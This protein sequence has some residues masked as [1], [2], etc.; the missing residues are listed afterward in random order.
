MIQ[1]ARG[2]AARERSMDA[3]RKLEPVEPPGLETGVVERTTGGLA[4]R[5]QTG[6]C[7]A[8]R[9]KSCLVVPE[10][11]DR[12]LCV[13]EGESVFVLA[14][15]DGRPDAR[16]SVDGSIA[17][18]AHAGRVALRSAGGIDLETTSDLQVRAKRGQVAVEQLGFVGRLLEAHAQKVSLVAHQV[19]SALGTLYQRAKR[20]FRRTEEIDQTRAGTVDVRADTLAALRA[21]NTVITSRVLTKIDADQVHIG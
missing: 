5:F 7:E 19:D 14:V 8:R 11:G 3:V 16:I 6:L 17:M 9:A 18:E 1:Y 2:T 12:V 10:P 21:D 20:A 4:V 13:T 15:L